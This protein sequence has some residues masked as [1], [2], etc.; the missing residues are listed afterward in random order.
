MLKVY[1]VRPMPLEDFL[2]LQ[3]PKTF[4]SKKDGNRHRYVFK[5]YV[6]ILIYSKNRKLFDIHMTAFLV[7]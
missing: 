2:K 7:L 6:D 3:L 5:Q 4:I 1:S